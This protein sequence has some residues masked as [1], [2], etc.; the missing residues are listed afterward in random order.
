MLNVQ[1]VSPEARRMQLDVREYMERIVAPKINQYWEKAEFPWE[2]LKGLADLNVMGGD[3]QGYGSV[4]L[5][6]RE[7]GQGE[8][9]WKAL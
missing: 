7:Y 4:G 6:I 5:P 8:K 3:I 2:F 1:G 9:K